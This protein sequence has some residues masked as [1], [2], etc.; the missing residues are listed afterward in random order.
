[1]ATLSVRN[2]AQLV[3]GQAA[4]MQAKCSRLLDFSAGSILR[5]IVESNAALAL[6]FQAQLLRVLAAARLATSTGPDADSYVGDFGLARLPAQS[7]LGSVTFTRFTPS[8]Q[9]VIPVGSLVQSADGTQQFRVIADTSNAAFN[10][11]LNGYVIPAGVGSL[12]VPVQAV[13][14]GTGGN[15]AA[16]AINT[17]VGSILYVDSVQNLAN[18]NGGAVAETDEAL[19]V[20]FQNF[21]A[22]LSKGTAPAIKFAVA[23]I[24]TGVDVSVMENVDADGVAD[25][26]FVCV[27]VDDGTGNPPDTLM[28]QAF[29]AADSV[30]AAGIILGCFRPAILAPSVRISL[31]VQAGY[32]QQVLVAQVGLA[33]SGYCAGLK[34]GDSLYVS[35]LTKR[36]LDV[37]VGIIKA[38]VFINDGNSDLIATP[39]NVIRPLLVTVA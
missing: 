17:I 36:A 8:A 33:I 12:A 2:F 9:A 30:R 27:T 16:G 21:I 14:T 29:A 20:R 4:A 15:V 6:W 25:P 23:S 35:Q 22:S 18:L 32:D 5:A 28:E 13:A 19:R 26:G 11:G 7:A 37:S 31:Q 38:T 10:V 1:M 24:R 3:Q 39:R 34:L